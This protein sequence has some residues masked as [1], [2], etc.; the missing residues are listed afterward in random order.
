MM[1]KSCEQDSSTPRLQLKVVVHV[2][3]EREQQWRLV[4][5]VHEGC[6]G[7]AAAG[8]LLCGLHLQRL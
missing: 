7:T 4:S 2:W 3:R 1:S 8:R 6:D 5:L